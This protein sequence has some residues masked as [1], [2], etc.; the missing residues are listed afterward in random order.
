MAV[1]FSD[2]IQNNISVL[3]EL[4][5]GQTP[6]QRKRASYAASQIEKAFTD[7]RKEANNDPAVILGT[8][9]AIHLLAQRLV[10]SRGEAKGEQRNLI[11]TLS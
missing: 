8:I 10:Q 9:F 7:L 5:A 2:S 1:E 11:Q 3:E 6:A 4:L